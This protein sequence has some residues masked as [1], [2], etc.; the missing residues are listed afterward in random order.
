MTP[1]TTP[2]PSYEAP[3][4]L[5]VEPENQVH[6]MPH[7]ERTRYRTAASRVKA[8]IPGP[9]GELV[10]RELMTIE[11]FGWSLGAQSQG[12]RLLRAVEELTPAPPATAHSQVRGGFPIRGTA[13]ETK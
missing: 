1:S 5:Y 8:A 4:T 7:T 11:E 2:Q 12:L 10:A 6:S 9:I 3:N 13:S